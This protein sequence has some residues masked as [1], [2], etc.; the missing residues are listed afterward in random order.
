M[1]YVIRATILAAFSQVFRH[2]RSL[3]I[4]RTLP[5]IT[6]TRRITEEGGG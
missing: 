3:S 5:P 4:L 1:P 2:F 6:S